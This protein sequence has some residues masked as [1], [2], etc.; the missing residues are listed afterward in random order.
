MTDKASRPKHSTFRW[1]SL[2]DPGCNNAAES[3]YPQL[4]MDW[5]VAS[6]RVKVCQAVIM[7]ESGSEVS[8]EVGKFLNKEHLLLVLP[9]VSTNAVE[10]K[11]DVF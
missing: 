11:E 10:Y 6:Q 3:S 9:H 8:M 5:S 1:E 4:R 2:G 7:G